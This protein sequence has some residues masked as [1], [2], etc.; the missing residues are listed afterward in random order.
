MKKPRRKDINRRDAEA[1]RKLFIV[2][3]STNVDA[4]LFALG[5][6]HEDGNANKFAPTRNINNQKTQ[7]LC[8]SA[9]KL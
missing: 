7:R 5:V 4:N 9:M 8:V 1:Q 6:T 2:G 3:N